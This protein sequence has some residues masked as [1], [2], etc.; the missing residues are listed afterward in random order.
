MKKQ[1]YIPV[2]PGHI[3]NPDDTR[4]NLLEVLG[5][6]DAEPMSLENYNDGR[7][8][9][10]IAAIEVDGKQYGLTEVLQKSVGRK[11]ATAFVA[12]EETT[13]TASRAYA[14]GDYF[15]YSGSLYETTVAIAQGG[16]IT[17]GTNC[18]AKP[19]G[20]G[21]EVSDLTSKLN[22]VAL[23]EQITGT[24]QITAESEGVT[25]YKKNGNRGYIGNTGNFTE[26]NGY[27]T[28]LYTIEADGY[29]WFNET[30]GNKSIALFNN[31]AIGSSNFIARYRTNDG[32]LPTESS[33]LAVTA[34]LLI[35]IGV[36]VSNGGVYNTFNVS[37]P[38][39]GETTVKL[40]NDVQFNSSHLL[41]IENIAKAEVKN[42]G[43]IARDNGD[44]I[45]TNGNARYTVRYIDRSDIRAY[46]WRIY[47]CEI[48]TGDGYAKVWE[49]S[50]ADGVV[51]IE[52]EDDFIGGYHGDETATAFSLYIDGVL[53]TE[54]T[55]ASMPYETIEIYQVS[56]VYHC[57]TSA[58]PDTVAFGRNKI[59]RFDHGG[60][61]ICNY[62]TAKEN[63]TLTYAYMG[64]LSVERYLSDGETYL[65]TGYYTD[66]DFAHVDAD[67]GTDA[68][69][70]ITTVTISTI[71]GDTNIKMGYITG[72]S[73][74]S[75]SVNDYDT[76]SS[77][78]LKVYAGLRN[79]SINTGETIKAEAIIKI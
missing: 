49:Q 30:S 60:V 61:H 43:T 11:A 57:N 25:E 19:N 34:G 74:Y 13:S 40:D 38:V 36:S 42:A 22:D 33:K 72:E 44:I 26:A 10:P 55:I 77:Q 67:T 12:Q 3:K 17:P 39:Q 32:N 69:S 20:L 73:D 68:N 53:H 18:E 79:K 41:T 52:G 71:Y 62:W 6:Q 47:K 54:T 45:I 51:R 4:T 23:F 58:S 31:G 64:M 16:T 14:V 56:E 1:R 8:N 28:F 75:A 2:I 21:G 27:A 7:N 66:K 15:V 35:A 46:L 65:I 9:P 24:K 70:T 48:Y 78:R 63:L 5:A 76:E 59:L 29:L 37:V 50:D